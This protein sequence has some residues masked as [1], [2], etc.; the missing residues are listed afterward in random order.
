MHLIDTTLCRPLYAL[1]CLALPPPP[2]HHWLA[3]FRWWRELRM[4]HYVHHMGAA[5]QNYAMVFFSVDQLFGSYKRQPP[6]QQ[7]RHAATEETCS[8]GPRYGAGWSAAAHVLVIR[9][10]NCLL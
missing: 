6:T 8:S 2:R 9:P 7:M 10:A 5:R 3:R 1:P 4:L